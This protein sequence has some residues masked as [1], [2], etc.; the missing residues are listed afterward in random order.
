MWVM[1]GSLI[2]LVLLVALLGFHTGPHTH[3]V[4]GVLGVGVAV[5]LALVA[6]QGRY[7]S[8]L[9][10]MGAV[11]FLVSVAV[12]I[13]AWKGLSAPTPIPGLRRISLE[14]AVG[15]AITD[16]DPEGIVRVGGEDWS[17]ASLNGAV[18]AGAR[19][20]VIT[21]DGVRIGVWGEENQASPSP[22]SGGTEPDWRES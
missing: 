21:A 2:G 10:M 12:G 13:L 18:R 11:L 14:G 4:A 9:A 19:V 7:F 15:K 1:A 20:Q 3:L 5:W 22:G 17:A 16:L 6:L 8:L